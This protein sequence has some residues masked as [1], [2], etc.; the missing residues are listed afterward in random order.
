[1]NNLYDLHAEQ[2]FQKSLKGLRFLLL[3][4]VLQAWVMTLQAQ[5]TIDLEEMQRQDSVLEANSRLLEEVS[6]IALTDNERVNRQAYNVTAIDARKLYNTTLDLA[7]ALDR[8]AGVRVRESGGVGSNVN[9]S[10]NGFSGRQVKIFIDG[11]P[12]DNFGSSFQLNNIPVNLAERVE[13]YKGV[14]PIWLGA[15]ALGGAVNIV[16]K[17][18]R[19][20]Y[21][22]LSYAYGSFNTHRT[23]LSGAVTGKNGLTARLNLYQ[24]YSDNNYWIHVDVADIKTGKYYPEQRVRR[25]HDQYHNETLIF[26]TG[27]VDKKWADELLIGLTL[28]ANRSEIQTGARMVTVFGDWYRKGNI[29]MP[30]LKY[31]KSNLLIKGL[32]VKLSGNFNLGQEQNIDTVYRRYNWFGQYKEYPGLGSERERSLYKYANNTGIAVANIN[33]NINAKNVISVNNVFNTFNRR[34]KDEFYPGQEKYNQPRV[35]SKNITGLGYIFNHNDRFTASLFVKNYLQINKMTNPVV[36]A[37]QT[38]YEPI[39]QLLN[40]QGY[41]AAAAY[42]ILKQ[43]QVKAS[44]E[45]S[46]RLPEPEEIFGDMINLEAN[47]ALKPERGDNF[48]LGVLFTHEGS[49]KHGFSTSANLIYRD[50]KDFIRTQ[51]NRNQVKLVMDNLFN[52]TNTGIEAEVN[53]SYKNWL[54]VGMNLTYQDIRNNTEYEQGFTNV[55][56]LYRDRIP[57]IPYLFGNANAGIRFRNVLFHSDGLNVGYNML[58]VHAYYLYWPS[59]GNDKLDIPRQVVHDINLVYTAAGGKYNLALECKNLGNARVYDNFSLQKPGRGIY[60]KVRYYLDQFKL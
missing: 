42:Y 35:N 10:L 47:P 48:N 54:Q 12:M 9:F 37:D 45:R 43:L 11:I 14:V 59:M 1:M 53:Y 25:F 2:P 57:N 39:Y 7:H 23:T 28:G 6:V 13:V 46:Y 19:K 4:V 56:P 27:L 44:Y 33:Y 29:V 34:G 22:D 5:Q 40:K 41:G 51:L 31:E 21:L 55:S 16:T 17:T 3:L 26:Q 58:Y 36:T 52:V 30:T 8:V 15:D 24:N 38:I 60:I 32:E 49:G 18:R 20:N 50:A